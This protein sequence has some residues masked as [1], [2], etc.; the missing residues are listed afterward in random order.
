MLP[1][2]TVRVGL[3]LAVGLLVGLSLRE[4]S[5][6]S[7]G[8]LSISN[9]PLEL[10]V[11][12]GAPTRTQI[13][14]DQTMVDSEPLAAPV[15][16]APIV[17][18]IK[19][20][21]PTSAT[22]TEALDRILD[23][24][25]FAEYPELFIRTL[26]LVFRRTFMC[27]D[28]R[29][30]GGS[31]EM[32]GDGAWS[33]CFD[34]FEA[35]KHRRVEM[36]RNGTLGPL[37]ASKRRRLKNPM[38]KNEKNPCIIYSFGVRDD[39]SFDDAMAAD[40]NCWIYSFDPSMEQW[41]DTLKRSPTSTFYKIGI[42]AEVHNKA[43]AT[44]IVIDDVPQ[45]PPPHEGP[46]GFFPMPGEWSLDT[47]AGIMSRLGHRYI[48][49]LKMDVEFAEW[50]VINE[51]A[52]SK[53]LERVDQFVLEVHFWAFGDPAKSLRQAVTGWLS[54][55]RAIEDS[56]LRNFGYN[57]NPQSSSE[58]FDF[59]GSVFCCFEV[60]YVRIH[61]GGPPTPPAPPA[62]PAPPPPEE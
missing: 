23:V 15:A 25:E 38:P 5:G 26:H 47:L 60:F 46:P 4:M 41:P 37:P 62:P 35:A 18:P 29:R 32:D 61:E 53:V 52:K 14:E 36:V 49:I 11:A 51:M 45:P 22:R 58:N 1:S 54:A 28:V 57:A 56:G 10:A 55:M 40:Y 20:A 8:G 9:S 39:F 24:E 13:A 33:I 27:K 6:D 7:L 17:A 12:S 3:S 19:P 21:F 44:P 43:V 30:I 16:E 59:G 50:D 48:S 34:F 2:G 42:R 31:A